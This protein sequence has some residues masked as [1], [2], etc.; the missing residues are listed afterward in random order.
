[1]AR[2]DCHAALPVLKNS[3]SHG[4]SRARQAPSVAVDVDARWAF[5]CWGRR[6]R[7]VG[8][9]RTCAIEPVGQCREGCAAH[10]R[11]RSPEAREHPPPCRRDDGPLPRATCGSSPRRR[12]RKQ[13]TGP[14]AGQIGMKSWQAGRCRPTPARRWPA[15]ERGPRSGRAACRPVPV[16]RSDARAARGSCPR[17]APWLGRA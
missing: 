16:S 13:H 2:Q 8:I 9:G 7:A 5:R 11:N 12:S 4:A 17:S 6:A 10:R 14:L 15:A 3:R 1:M